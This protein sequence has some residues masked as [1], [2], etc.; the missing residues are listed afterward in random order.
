[1][2]WAN[3]TASH[4]PLKGLE[5]AGGRAL[6]TRV[7]VPEDRGQVATA[8][9]LHREPEATVSVEPELVDGHDA[10]VVEL[11]RDL[12]LL[13]EALPQAGRALRIDRQGDDL[14]R[15]VSPELLVDH[16]EHPPHATATDLPQDPV[17]RGQG[18][19]FGQALE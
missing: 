3:A 19:P 17:A 7:R 4:T 14:H 16:L 15:E 5:Q 9:E 13:E 10:G 18:G 12:G 11:A 1:M 6:V 8:D 2:S